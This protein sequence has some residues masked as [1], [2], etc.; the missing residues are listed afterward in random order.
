MKTED[1]DKNCKC[2]LV[3]DCC[4]SEWSD[5]R[6]RS[7]RMI[8][9]FQSYATIHTVHALKCSGEHCDNSLLFDGS[10]HN[11]T[12]MEFRK[13]DSTVISMGESHRINFMSQIILP[14]HVPSEA[15]CILGQ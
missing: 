1:I 5:N 14:A 8:V 6:D 4:N 10:E 9:L 15:Q 2:K 11:I 12:P 13:N 3:C 7:S